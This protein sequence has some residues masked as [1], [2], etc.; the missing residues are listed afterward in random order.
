[1]VNITL[2]NKNPCSQN[3]KVTINID[4]GLC[5]FTN[6][7]EIALEQ[8]INDAD[9]I[10]PLIHEPYTPIKN[11]MFHY[12]YSTIE[13]LLY[14]G[15][16]VYSRLIK[17]EK[18]H[19]CIFRI[20]PSPL[21]QISPSA[22]DI[23]FS[24]NRRQFAQETISI[25][26][27]EALIS[28]LS[29]FKFVFSEAIIVDSQFTIKDLPLSIDGDALYTTDK[30]LITLLKTPHDF[31]RYELRY[32]NPEI[33]FGV[34]SKGTIEKGEIISFYTGIKTHSLPETRFSFI[35][36]QD[37][38]M[39]KIDASQYGNI[40]RFINHAPKHNTSAQSTFI[41][42]NINSSSHYLNGLEM[43]VYSATKK[44][45]KGEQ[46]LVDY[47]NNFFQDEELFLFK[48][49]GRL[50][51]TDRKLAWSNSQNTL[52]NLKIMAIYGVK[53][54]RLY[55]LLRMLFIFSL[56]VSAL[57]LTSILLR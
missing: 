31:S 42:A 5:R 56:F 21:F 29:Q 6:N 51:R 30:K 18:P 48:T 49:N 53:K 39:M 25:H 11:Q 40:T 46:L 35:Q 32:I 15:I 54:A 19:D 22:K 47:G 1:M 44:I 2:S 43:I 41:E 20:N 52:N 14:S 38:F 27:L 28:H 55:V 24:I 23:P 12:E 17:A 10:H 45:F 26:Q 3:R 50:I 16:F 36:A 37:C 34:F 7:R 4:T 8:L 33:G 13:E 9:F 57:G